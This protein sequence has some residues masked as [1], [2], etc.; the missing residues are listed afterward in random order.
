ME[1]NELIEESLLKE[2]ESDKTDKASEKHKERRERRKVI[3]WYFIGLVFII[4]MLFQ[5]GKAVY[6]H[7]NEYYKP[8]YYI[9][10]T[11]D[12]S[13]RTDFSVNIY[14]EEKSVNYVFQE[15]PNWY[16]STITGVFTDYLS[17]NPDNILNQDYKISFTFR[18]YE[19]GYR[20]HYTLCS[21][22]NYYRG[23][24]HKDFDTIICYWLS[25]LDKVVGDKTAD[26]KYASFY[27]EDIYDHKN[28]YENCFLHFDRLIE[29]DI[30]VHPDDFDKI[31]NKIKEINP[32]LILHNTYEK[33]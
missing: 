33:R 6:K 4:L 32:E 24:L 11:L 18:D 16:G 12:M 5:I 27:G 13:S 22:C 3:K 31:Y 14:K 29:A 10:D 26:F 17:E 8:I 15:I 25:N 23:E 7:I 21:I 9:I 2:N 1:D 28:Y 20:Y 19:Y 30:D